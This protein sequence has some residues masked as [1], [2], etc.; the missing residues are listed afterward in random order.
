MKCGVLTAKMADMR[1]PEGTVTL[2]LAD[3]EGSTG[4]W[5]VEPEAMT[6]AIARLDAVVS[7]VIGARGGFRPLAMK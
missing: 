6:S 2:L 3:V 4:L 7:D 1:L 5:E